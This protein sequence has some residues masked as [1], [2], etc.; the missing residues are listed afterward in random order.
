MFDMSNIKFYR[1]LN[2]GDE[3]ICGGPNSFIEIE[4][5]S[6][7]NLFSDVGG[8]FC[9]WGG[10]R[11]RKMF[12]TNES[13]TDTLKSAYLFVSSYS[14]KD[15]L[16]LHLGSDDDVLY[17]IID[18]YT[19]G[20]YGIG[21]LE[22]DVI[23]RST[24]PEGLVSEYFDVQS[25]LV[26]DGFPNDL[27]YVCLSTGPLYEFAEVREVVWGIGNNVRIYLRHQ[28]EYTFES[29]NAFV[30]AMLFLG[31]IEPER[32]IPVWIKQTIPVGNQGRVKCRSY[33]RLVGV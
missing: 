29:V 20:W 3:L 25:T 5:N 4:N 30:S 15:N 6:L 7:T 10:S 21:L 24:Q 11:Y 13:T 9:L 31:D 8:E 26:G 23:G 2:W 17:E 16:S 22:T 1:S 18:A 14:G 33:I 12:L 19:D 28:L 27:R 32:S